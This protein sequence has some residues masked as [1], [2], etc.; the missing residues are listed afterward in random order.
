MKERFLRMLKAK[1]EQRDALKAK[2]DKTDDVATL[3]SISSQL[4]ELNEEVR[5]LQASITEIEAEEA[6]AAA[7]AGTGDPLATDKTQAKRSR[8]PEEIEME[9]RAAA[10]VGSYGQGL[11]TEARASIV[12]TYEE[13][14]AALRSKQEINVPF[15]ET[16]EE[17]AVTIGGGT[18]I[19]ETK[20]SRTLNGK[21]N[22][23]S[24]L[25]DRVSAVPLDGGNS[26]QKGFE[27]SDG[28]A[29]Y[30]TETG[31][32]TDV[33]PVFGYVP[34]GK[35]KI[36]AYIEITDEAANLPNV[37]YQA[38]VTNSIRNAIRKKLTRQI[39]VGTG[40][41]N[42]L[43]GILN[44]P[45]NVIPAT[46]IDIVAIDEDTLDTI[47]YGYGGDEDVEGEATLILNKKDLAAFA[48]VRGSDG[49][50]LYE[51]EK[52]GNFGTITSKGG[53]TVPW[54]INSVLPALS[55]VGT[56]A[57]TKCMVY[58]KLNMYEMP[59]FSPLNVQESK[60]F[61]FKSGQIAYRGVIWA[62]G[63]VAMYKGF[64][65]IKKVAGA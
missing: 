15:N 39:L 44:A 65:I 26:Y 53:T 48:A 28:E 7:N 16:A 42:T 30:T 24:S 34:I 64:S 63:N 56:V 12:K 61:K 46:T 27:V 1:Q 29:G 2:I 52:N 38:M 21:F 40:G 22:E 37:A 19:V 32:Y 41:A 4:D 14:G 11:S 10:I 5:E 31:D 49:T 51:I 25:I 35:A 55:L 3:R 36:T 9:A 62:G 59:I 50:K 13:R 43:T 57:N 17:R 47:I 60:D 23:V 45:V 58:G 18:L 6:R 54:I 33:D 20:Y 8:T